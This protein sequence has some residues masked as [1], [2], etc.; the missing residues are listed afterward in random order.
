MSLAEKQRVC[1]QF[2]GWNTFAVSAASL[3]QR[4][5]LTRAPVLP[6]GEM[7]R[8]RSSVLLPHPLGPIR[9]TSSPFSTS[10][11]IPFR[12]SSLLLPE[13]N[14]FLRSETFSMTVGQSS[15]LSTYRPSTSGK[16]P[17]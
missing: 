5:P 3:K 15:S 2:S 13:P 11:L 17:T 10:R 16:I 9:L 14:P 7:A 6:G 4:L 8:T 1:L 12:T